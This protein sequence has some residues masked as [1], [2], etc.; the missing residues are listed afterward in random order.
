MKTYKIENN[1]IVLFG[2]ENGSFKSNDRK[3]SKYN[4]TAKIAQ[5]YNEI[6]TKLLSFLKNDK[7]PKYQALSYACLLMMKS[8]I[9]IG[10]ESSAEGYV[11]KVKGF[12][13]QFVETY[14]LTTLKNEHINILSDNIDNPGKTEPIK[15]HHTIML[16]FVGKKVVQQN[17]EIKDTLLAHYGQYFKELN[18]DK[19]TWLD[20]TNYELTK[21]I[22]KY[23]GSKFVPKDFRTLFAN[24]KAYEEHLKLLENEPPKNKKEVKQELKKII[25]N[26][27]ESLG[28]TPSI[29]KKA[30][31]D[32]RLLEYHYFQRYGEPMPQP[33]KRKK[34]K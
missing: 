6:Y 13:G 16:D 8:G 7:K 3:L 20:I 10:N 15:L 1:K 26:T 19:E 30:Y 28:N 2:N 21:F 12:E 17:I 32:N 27:S 9:R 4:R 33:K 24:V 23:I 31:V 22:K 34:K 29:C 5:N 11:T 18:K 25:E 14:G